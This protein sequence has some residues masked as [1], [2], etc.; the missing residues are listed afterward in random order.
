MREE[1]GQNHRARLAESASARTVGDVR[2][3]FKE[4]MARTA[5]MRVFTHY[6]YAAFESD[7]IFPRLVFLLSDLNEN[8]R[9][10]ASTLHQILSRQ[11]CMADA[12]GHV[13]P[14]RIEL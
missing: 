12:P 3:A 1:L 4:S 8:L 9:A 11:R 13:P 6:A 14:C 10:M 7:K 2:P 5:F